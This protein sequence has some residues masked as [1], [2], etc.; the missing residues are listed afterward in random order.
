[1][2]TVVSGHKKLFYVIRFILLISFFLSLR[3]SDRNLVT[4]LVHN[5][6]QLRVASAYLGVRHAGFSNTSQIVHMIRHSVSV[7]FDSEL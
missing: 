2:R 6:L 7:D 5:V 3:Y 4:N 1:M